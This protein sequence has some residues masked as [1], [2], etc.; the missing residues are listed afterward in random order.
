LLALPYV[1]P[2]IFRAGELRFHFISREERRIHVHVVSP[3][4]E[5]RVKFPWFRE[6]SVRSVFK[7]SRPSHDHLRWAELDVDV[8]LDSLAHPER[9]PLVSRRPVTVRDGAPRRRG[10]LAAP[11]GAVRRAKA[12]PPRAGRSAKRPKR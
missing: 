1:T 2:T 8:D 5:A 10:A 9:Y 3:L 12:K 7:V 11:V 6:A 4:E